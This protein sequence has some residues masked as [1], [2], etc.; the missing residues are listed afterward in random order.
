M[1]KSNVLKSN[2]LKLNVSKSNDSKFNDLTKAVVKRKRFCGENVELAVLGL[3]VVIWFFLFS[4][5]P[6]FGIVIA[7]KRYQPLGSN[8][9]D[10]LLKSEWIGLRNFRFLFLTPDAMIVFRNTILYNAVFILSGILVAVSLAIMMSLLHSRKMAKTAQTLIFLPHFLSWVVVGYFVYSFLH[11]DK[12]LVNQVLTAAGLQPRM[13]YMEPKYWPYF[14]FFINIW[15]GMGYGMVV[16]LAGIA[17]ID[18]NLYEAAVIDGATKSR[19]VWSIVLPMLKPIITIMFILAVGRIF[20]SDFGLFYFIPKQS[21]LLFNVTQTVDVYVYN[22]LMQQN[23]LGFA[24]AANFI[25]SVAG[26]VTIFTANCVV[27]KL[28]SGNS[29][30]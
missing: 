29:L 24:S 12:G 22:A 15:K 16:Y 23:N 11:H 27:K 6:I 18:T 19:Q 9:I 13:W 5:L 2:D 4:Y 25:Q 21:G 10:S 1:Y 17:G 30:F 8:F 26:F 3:P 20:M 7:F 14:L 28:D